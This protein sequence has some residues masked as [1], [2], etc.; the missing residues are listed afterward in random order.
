[1][2]PVQLPQIEQTRAYLGKL[3][4]L[5][6]NS[7]RST[8]HHHQRGAGGK[9]KQTQGATA[10]QNQ[11]KSGKVTGGCLMAV[12]QA[13]GVPGLLHC[14]TPAVCKLHVG[15]WFGLGLICYTV[16]K[17]LTLQRDSLGM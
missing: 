7:L 3:S 4:D 11:I 15:F 13:L 14:L 12:G 10:I 17:R 2:W 16:V 9:E 8:T 5:Q 1:M 6:H